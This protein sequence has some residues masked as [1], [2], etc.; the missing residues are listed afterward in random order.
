M[1]DEVRA[2]R[3]HGCA[4][5]VKIATRYP[6]TL[7]PVFDFLR[8]TI[9]DELYCKLSKMEFVT[10]VEGL[11][12]IS[13]ELR[14]FDAQARFIENLAKPVCNQLKNLENHFA[15]PQA[16]TSFIGKTL[17]EGGTATRPILFDPF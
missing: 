2:L 7:V 12:L 5:M 6:Q 15:T 4:L 17:F 9:V 3:R 11:V 10:L 16:F 1:P 14:N 8:Q 13:N